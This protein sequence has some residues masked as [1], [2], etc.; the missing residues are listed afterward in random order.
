MKL[1]A[2]FGN[3]GVARAAAVGLAVA[4]AHGALFADGVRRS[5]EAVA[6]GCRVTLAWSF[7]AKAESDLVIEERLSEGWSVDGSTVPFSS[8]DAS[9]FTSGGARFAVKP[10]LLAKDGSISFVVRAAEGT[11]ACI[12]DGDWRMYLGGQLRHSVITG[13]ARLSVAGGS[14]EDGDSVGGGD[15]VEIDITSFK[16]VDAVF[17]EVSYAAV[18]GYGTLVV[19]G[20]AGL[21]GEWKE[22]KRVVVPAGE[23]RVILKIREV[24]DCRFLRLKFFKEGK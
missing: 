7:S 14:S 10:E 17:R 15:G 21:D 16:V 6:G 20:C 9:S 5:V 19:E 13:S 4:L 1:K 11:P 18:G 2:L 24:G 3:H 23:G 12:A 22:I 8:L